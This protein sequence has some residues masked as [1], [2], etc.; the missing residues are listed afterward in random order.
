MENVSGLTEEQKLI[1]EQL[2]AKQESV[3]CHLRIR[4]ESRCKDVHVDFLVI[5][6]QSH[7]T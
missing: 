3:R 1:V 5:L 7:I 6:T 4:T 2:K